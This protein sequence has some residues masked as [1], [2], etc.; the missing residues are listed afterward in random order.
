MQ[1]GGDRAQLRTVIVIAKEPVP[2][3]VKTRLVPPLTHQQAADLA[4]AA[5][6]DTLAAAATVAAQQ[7]LLVLDGRPPAWLP[8]GWPVVAQVDGGLDARLVAAFEA[9][10]PGPAILVGMDTPQ[11][12]AEQLNAFDPVAFD[13]C[14]GLAR[15]GGYWVIGYRDPALARSTI[16]GVPMSRDDTG[17]R[18]LERLRAA[19]L[20]VQLL[21]ELTDVDT[22]PDA[23]AVA[24]VAPDTRF[25]AALAALDLAVVV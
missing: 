7:H 6:A 2:G 22:Y 14:L 19:G 20:R 8:T 10:R 24:A 15:D 13:A 18:Q 23:V 3:R 11:L 12:R 9:A 4:A 17:A 5:I 1:A 21:D 25:A 16:T